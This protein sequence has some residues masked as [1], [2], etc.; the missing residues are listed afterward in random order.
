M[1]Y[2]KADYG[3]EE[4]DRLLAISDSLTDGEIEQISLS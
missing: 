3:E 4:A 2:S 1:D